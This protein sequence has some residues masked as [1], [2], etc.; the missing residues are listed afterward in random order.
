MS[1]IFA[2][3]KYDDMMWRGQIGDS[4]N[5]KLLELVRTAG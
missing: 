3:S 1:R 5:A 4:Q 2:Y